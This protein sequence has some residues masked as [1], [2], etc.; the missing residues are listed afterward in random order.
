MDGRPLG[1]GPN[2]GLEV[3]THNYLQV[4]AWSCS[5]SWKRPG[6]SLY[7]GDICKCYHDNMDGTVSPGWTRGQNDEWEHSKDA[8]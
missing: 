4:H 3:S 2:T 6:T 7:C 1:Y 5:L 8:T